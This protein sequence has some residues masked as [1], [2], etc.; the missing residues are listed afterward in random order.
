M[1]H[2]DDARA[3]LETY[4]IGVTES[5]KEPAP[6]KATG[7]SRPV[8]GAPAARAAPATSGSTGARAS[9]PTG[10]APSEP[11]VAAAEDDVGRGV[12]ARL[13]VPMLLLLFAV[14]YTFYLKRAPV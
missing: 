12:L 5:K 14:F 9:K 1:G 10:A 8:S 4:L 11:A 3:L 7:A 6:I 13:L 2:S